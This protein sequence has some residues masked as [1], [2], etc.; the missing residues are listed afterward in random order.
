MAGRHFANVKLHHTGD[1]FEQLVRAGEQFVRGVRVGR[2]SPENNDVRKHGRIVVN[3]P[4]AASE[5]W[6][7]FKLWVSS[8]TIPQCG[9]ELQPSRSKIKP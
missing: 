2:V 4:V 5:I 7:E 9:I 3:V 8:R 6:L 1:V